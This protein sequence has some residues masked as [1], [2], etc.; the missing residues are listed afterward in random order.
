M[1]VA[2][3][4]AAGLSAGNKAG[5]IHGN[6]NPGNILISYPADGSKQA[7]VFNFGSDNAMTSIPDFEY[8]SPEQCNGAEFP[9]QRSDVYSL[10]VVLYEMLAGERPFVGETAAEMM[11]KHA[12]EPPPP[13]AAFRN[14]LAPGIEPIVVKALSKDPAMRPSDADVLCE[15]FESLSVASA[16]NDQMARAWWEQHEPRLIEQG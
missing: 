10:G 14:D 12:E 16:W 15:R 9:D 3:Q 8:L 5:L 11:R 6:L 13:L 1:D 7:K 4:V 2:K